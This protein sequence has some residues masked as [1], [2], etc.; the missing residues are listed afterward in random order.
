MDSINGVLGILNIY[1]PEVRRKVRRAIRGVHVVDDVHARCGTGGGVREAPNERVRPPD[2]AKLELIFAAQCRRRPLGSRE[3]GYA[4][5][6]E[7][8]AP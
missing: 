4:M 5:W 1:R 3:Q 2:T 8:I 6:N 7:C